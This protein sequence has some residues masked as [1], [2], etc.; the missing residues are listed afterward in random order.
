MKKLLFLLCFLI[1]SSL[2]S[3]QKYSTKEVVKSMFAIM[4]FAEEQRMDE[5]VD[6]AKSVGLKP[7]VNDNYVFDD[8]PN[9]E[10][11]F[12]FQL[13]P[14]DDGVKIL[15]IFPEMNKEDF[16]SGNIGFHSIDDAYYYLQE[17]M[18]E[19]SPGM[20][21][22]FW[23]DFYEASQKGE[24][25]LEKISNRKLRD[26]DNNKIYTGSNFWST[27]KL[28]YIYDDYGDVVGMGKASG[29]FLAPDNLMLDV[30]FSIRK[31]GTKYTIVFDRVISKSE[32]KTK[33]F[34]LEK[35][36]KLKNLYD[37]T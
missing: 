12:I 7:S 13:K 36:L 19:L 6:Y 37:R 11:P 31:L 32:N 34:N 9:Y 3:Q 17:I 30:N 18:F 33:R 21:W 35:L 15:F 8:F 16:L 24:M 22:R 1:S 28:E 10:Y 27:S 2:F 20:L 25:P 29:I 14:V 4:A 26:K 5:M 23:D